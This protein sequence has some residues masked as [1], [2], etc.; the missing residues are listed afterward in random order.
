MEQCIEFIDESAARSASTKRYIFIDEYKIEIRAMNDRATNENDIVIDHGHPLLYPP[1]QDSPQNIV[2]IL[3]DDCLREIFTNLRLSEAV[4]VACVCK[5]FNQIAKEVFQWKYTTKQISIDS[6]MHELPQLMQIECFLGIFGSLI[7]SLKVE[8]YTN[9]AVITMI[10]VYCTSLVELEMGFC[11]HLISSTSRLFSRL[12]KLTLN[13]DFIRRRDVLHRNLPQPAQKYMRFYQDI[14]SA[15]VQLENLTIS[16]KK[17][18]LCHFLPPIPLPKLIELRLYQIYLLS[19]SHVGN[20]VDYN[21][22]LLFSEYNRQIKVVHI[23]RQSYFSVEKF[24]SIST[25]FKNKLSIERLQFNGSY[26]NFDNDNEKLVKFLNQLK[27]LGKFT[28]KFKESANDLPIFEG[29]NI[30]KPECVNFSKSN[31]SSADSNYLANILKLT[32][33]TTL[34]F[35]HCNIS[36]DNLIKIVASCQSL[37][38]LH[39]ELSRFPG[40][41]DRIKDFPIEK[42]IHYSPQLIEISFTLD[43][44]NIEYFK[45][46]ENYNYD[47]I[48]EAVKCRSNSNKLKLKI[49]FCFLHEF[50]ELKT[51]FVSLNASPE[52]LTI[53]KIYHFDW[54]F[55][56]MFIP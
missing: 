40:S 12:T 20:D 3:N 30:T 55:Y 36:H 13:D 33:V 25:I 16:N 26:D 45:F 52:W 41:F 34:R 15:C 47:R 7:T 43:Y 53:E 32:H 49:K 14:I 27:Y 11:E 10:D 35:Y 44:N 39:I 9:S 19:P 17:I 1:A 37:R 22:M 46:A 31:F 56:G 42:L 5:R 24:L 29:L 2:N 50:H 38:R 4:A 28:Y 54:P 48:L 23:Q 21:A 51:K 18:R 6:L 8:F